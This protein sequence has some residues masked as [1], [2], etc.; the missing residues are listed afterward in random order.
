MT[1]EET[2]TYNELLREIRISDPTKRPNR[3]CHLREFLEIINQQEY[4][5]N[6]LFS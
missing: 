4:L 3:L 1:T 6:D 5:E 2:Q